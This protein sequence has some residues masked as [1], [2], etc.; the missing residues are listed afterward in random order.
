ML[1]ERKREHIVVCKHWCKYIFGLI[2]WKKKKKKKSN[3]LD[4]PGHGYSSE[5]THQE[6]NRFEEI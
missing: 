5:H 4:Y 3:F 6:I 2:W 1:R